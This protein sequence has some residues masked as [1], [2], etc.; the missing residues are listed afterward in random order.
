[1]AKRGF[2][3][4]SSADGTSFSARVGRYYS[5]GRS[6]Y[7]AIGENLLWSS[8]DVDAA[9]ALRLWLSSAPHRR[10]LLRAHWREIGLSAVHTSAGPGA[11]RN[12]PVTIV[13]ADFGVRR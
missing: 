6:G 11:F 9:G 2:F 12:A 10:N 3:S 8:P 13:T 4:H 7:R 1:M 5:R